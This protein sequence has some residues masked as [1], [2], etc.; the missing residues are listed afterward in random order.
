[1]RYISVLVGVILLAALSAA[2]QQYIAGPAS[3]SPEPDARVATP[4]PIAQNASLFALASPILDTAVKTPAPPAQK[5]FMP[6]AFA[7]P[8]ILAP[9]SAPEP[10][11]IPGV[12]ENYSWQAYAGYT[13]VRFYELPAVAE[14]QNGV[15][16]GIT[17]FYNDWLGVDVEALGVHGTLGGASSWTMFVG[18]GPR[19]R[20]WA[21]RNLEVFGH[22]LIGGAAFWPDTPYGSQGAFG[23]ELG[24]GVD[25]RPH[26]SRFSLRLQGDLLGTRFFQTNQWSPK[27]SAGLVYK[28]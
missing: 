6:A 26:R 20:M 4:A 16:G 9:S 3:L 22:T 14:N 27:V 28:F 12:F 23:Y 18:V 25:F 8:V 15:N 10:Q 1:M 11:A 2:A 24:G 5:M 21:G 7:D 19:L 13:F 17:W